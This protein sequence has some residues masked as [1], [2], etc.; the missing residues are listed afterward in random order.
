[1]PIGAG[2]TIII[3]VHRVFA[4]SADTDAGA[5]T[6]STVSARIWLLA[7]SIHT[8]ARTE[9]AIVIETANTPTV[10]TERCERIDRSARG[11]IS[12]AI[13]AFSVRTDSA[14]GAVGIDLAG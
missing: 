7:Q 3:A 5:K 6:L 12:A 13:G 10:R 4:R 11:V 1:M 9:T 14:F 2:F 8:S